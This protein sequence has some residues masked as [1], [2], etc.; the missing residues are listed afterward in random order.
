[1][2]LDEWL[3]RVWLAIPEAARPAA[4][5]ALEAPAPYRSALV[6]ALAILAWASIH[7]ALEANRG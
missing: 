7:L 4:A 2:T 1:M 3:A 5:L 6:M